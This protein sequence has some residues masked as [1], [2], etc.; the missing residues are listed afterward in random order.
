MSKITPAAWA[1]LYGNP[2]PLKEVILDK[3][4]FQK[5][6][7]EALSRIKPRE[8]RVLVWSTP[9]MALFE[10]EAFDKEHTDLPSLMRPR[11]T[12]HGTVT[13][14]FKCKQNIEEADSG[15]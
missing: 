6:D 5:Q 9:K 12:L 14:R 15:T 7:Y 1:A 11:I 4:D 8:R 2:R 13:G 3:Q 10:A